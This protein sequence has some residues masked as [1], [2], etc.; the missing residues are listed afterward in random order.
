MNLIQ[1]I[2]NNRKNT[3]NEL[4]KSHLEKLD[5]KHN[6]KIINVV[7]TNGKGSISHYLTQNLKKTFNVGTFTSPHIFEA[8][9][10]I[11][12]N[13]ISIPT[14]TLEKYILKYINTDIH[15][16]GIMFL[17]AIEYF[18]DKKCDIVILEA[19]IGGSHDPSNILDGDIGILTSIGYDHMEIFGDTLND[20]LLDKIGIINK[21][22]NFYSGTQ[23]GDMNK[24][25]TD[26]ALKNNANHF[27][28]A[29]H[30]KH[31]K[32]RNQLITKEVLEKEFN[33]KAIFD[34]PLGRTTIQEIN[35]TT[36]IL[37][38][39]HNED[40][41]LATLEYL[42]DKN[43]S[44]EQV[45]ITIAKRKDFSNLSNIFADKKIFVYQLDNSFISAN[46]I[47]ALTVSNLREFYDNQ[48]KNTLYIGSFYSIGS[49]LKNEDKQ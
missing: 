20:V 29:N 5:L 37:D 43:I 28:V 35:H 34:E 14:S 16:F 15:F 45:V 30:E 17:S 42:K 36:A 47:E 1:S 11:K 22:M 9:E 10:R 13:G 27:I 44:F 32:T 25:I 7:G 26:K 38:V 41:I 18:N 39:A 31:Y 48:K 40:G 12:F 6:F 8:N 3:S 23:L 46:E 19:G 4:L 21:D 24:Q 33:I 49:V 2:F